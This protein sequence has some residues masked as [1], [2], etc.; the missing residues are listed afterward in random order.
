MQLL[1]LF[2]ITSLLA[3]VITSYVPVQ[4][5]IKT[6]WFLKSNCLYNINNVKLQIQLKYLYDFEILLMALNDLK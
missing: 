3:K 5:D 2:Q 1:V 4:S 6:G